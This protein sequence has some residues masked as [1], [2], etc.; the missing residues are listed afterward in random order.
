M[1]KE[2]DEKYFFFLISILPISIIAGPSISL[3]NVVFLNFLF[4][5]TIFK[6]KE[7]NFFKNYAV[8][9]IIFLYIYLIFNSFISIDYEV[10]LVRN[11]GFIRIILLFICIN[12]FFYFYQNSQ[13]FIK[14]WTIIFI[15]FILDVFLE[16][17]SGSNLF[18]WGALEIDGLTQIYADR[19]VSFFKDEPVAGAFLSGFIFIITGYLLLNNNNKIL[20]FTFLIISFLAILLTGERAN[21]IKVLIGIFVFFFLIDFFNIKTKI[22]LSLGIFSIFFIIIS[23]ST[24]LKMRYQHQ[25]IGK[26]NSKENLTNFYENNNY[27]KLYQSGIN[28]FKNNK[29]FGVGNKNYRVETC[30]QKAQIKKIY[31]CSTHPHQLY[32]E[33]L[34]EHGLIGSIILLSIF[35]IIMFK[36]LREIKRT[37]NYLQMGA[38]TFVLLNFI[39]IIPSGSFFGDFNLTIFWINLSIMFACN[40]NTNIFAKI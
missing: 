38:F 7:F 23:Q 2:G 21:A 18:G 13:K 12:Y 27:M 1:K 25:I 3:L 29:I 6:K 8:K 9:L 39:P 34:S 5:K 17:F 19:V 40:R 14:Y 30:G 10:G 22:L 4:L 24:Y 26:I 35:F 36:I 33:F 32:V 31:I 20:P 11:L 16:K 28:V 37:Q 15:I